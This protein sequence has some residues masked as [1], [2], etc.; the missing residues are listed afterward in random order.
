MVLLGSSGDSP[1]G[2]PPPSYRLFAPPSCCSPSL[3]TPTSFP[4]ASP[5]LAPTTTPS[6]SPTLSPS[7]AP[8]A[9]P[10]Q[11]P[12]QTPTEVRLGRRQP[13]PCLPLCG[14]CVLGLQDFIGLIMNLLRLVTPCPNPQPFQTPFSRPRPHHQ[15]R[16][17]RMARP[18]PPRRRHREA[19]Q[20]ARAR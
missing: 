13:H 6:S 9:G 14:L 15:P 20:A 17:P 5:S 11:S 4:S 1:A 12:S 2:D 3:Q 8:A 18:L 16:Y 7:T 19:P 10:S